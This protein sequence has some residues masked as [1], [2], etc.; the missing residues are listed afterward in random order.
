LK[1][2]EKESYFLFQWFSNQSIALSK[3]DG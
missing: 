3:Q 2:I 1:T